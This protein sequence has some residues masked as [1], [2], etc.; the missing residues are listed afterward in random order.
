M[1]NLSLHI[2]SLLIASFCGLLTLLQV[3]GSAQEIDVLNEL[4][5]EKISEVE[6]QN[7]HL[8][9]WFKTLDAA[10]EKTRIRRAPILLLAGAEW[11]EPCRELEKEL[12][13]QELQVELQK[14]VPVHIDIDEETKTAREFNINAIPAFHLLTP[15]GRLI[16]SRKGFLPAKELSD[17]LD[18]QYD[19]AAGAFLEDFTE[20]GTPGAIAVIRIVREFSKRDATLR[21]AAITRLLPHPEV[22]AAHVLSKLNG[23]SLSEKLTALELLRAWNAPVQEIDP[24]V[25]ETFDEQ[26]RER[27]EDWLKQQS[28]STENGA[29]ALTPLQIIEAER[30]LKLM[31]EVDAASAAS[32]RDQLSRMGNGV[33]PLLKEALLNE[34]EEAARERLLSARY[35]LAISGERFLSWSGGVERMASSDFD[36]RIKAINEF[37]AVATANDEALLLALFE[38]SEPLVRELAI[39]TLQNVS[40]KGSTNNTLAK[41]LDDPDANVRAAALKYLSESPSESLID[42]ISEYISRENDP[43]LVVFAIRYLSEVHSDRSVQ[44]LLPLFQHASWRVRAD[45][46]TAVTK[47]MKKEAVRKKVNPEEIQ[48]AFIELLADEDHFVVSKALNALGQWPTE[49][50]F[51]PLL[52]AAKRSPEL[53][54]QIIPVMTQSYLYRREITPHLDAFLNHSESSVRA[55]AISGIIDLEPEDALVAAK[56]ALNDED[57]RVAVAAIHAV[58]NQAFQA[59]NNVKSERLRDARVNSQLVDVDW[60]DSDLINEIHQQRKLAPWIYEFSNALE[61]LIGSDADKLSLAAHRLRATLGKPDSIQYLIEHA[62]QQEDLKYFADVLPALAW[63]PRKTLFDQLMTSADSV[64]NKYYL[65]TQLAQGF[66]PLAVDSLWNLLTENSD[67]RDLTSKLRRTFLSGYFRLGVYQLEDATVQEKEK[68]QK[69][70]VGYLTSGTRWQKVNALHLLVA[71]APEVAREEAEKNFSD[72]AQSSELRDDYFRTLLWCSSPMS[73]Q[74]LA[75]KEILSEDSDFAELA[76]TYLTLGKSEIVSLSSGSY[77]YTYSDR[78]DLNAAIDVPVGISSLLSTQ[79]L[80]RFKYSSNPFT[81]A[82]LGFCLAMNGDSTFLPALIAA[83]EADKNHSGYRRLLYHATSKINEPGQVKL[84]KKIYRYVQKDE[85]ETQDFYAKL[86]TMTDPQVAEFL[87]MIQAEN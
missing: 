67:G 16:A 31:I 6:E 64:S 52:S 38:S 32:M 25:P 78:I 80:E 21:E 81:L 17:W 19:S 83:W 62:D 79:N 11:C 3:Q 77:L 23:G 51:Q 69:D 87:K 75:V 26:S 28:F 84:L 55:A 40:T 71:I 49:E 41:L 18:S 72:E 13:D 44:V 59:I 76:L 68:I 45:T 53:A 43:D 63:E 36:E 66:E 42:Q 27:L 30:L 57:S 82:Q 34:T 60:T 22:A 61:E 48:R 1:S 37:A 73:G 50:A 33:L 70:C 86:K 39:Q 20:T 15:D 85:A 47:L 7:T 10:K 65:A 56:N 5:E 12:S 8:V 74:K 14:W 9:T 35:R 46:A 4:L 58:F 2:R 54:A 24:W 29:V